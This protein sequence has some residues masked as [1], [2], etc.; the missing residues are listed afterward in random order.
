[1][2]VDNRTRVVPVL[3]K[4]MPADLRADETLGYAAYEEVQG[5]RTLRLDPA[6]GTAAAPTASA[7]AGPVVV[8]LAECAADRRDDRERL[9]AE[10]KAHQIRML[11]EHRLPE[12]QRDCVA[13]VDRLLAQCQFSIHPV[14]AGDGVVPDGPGMKSGSVLQYECAIRRR[15][16]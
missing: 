1:M 13:E 8:Y 14:G 9:R 16:R 4:P 11:P 6:F 3:L 5:R 10:L 7:D 15:R 2:V 12:L